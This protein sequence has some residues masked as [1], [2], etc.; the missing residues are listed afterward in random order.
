MIRWLAPSRWRRRQMATADLLD[1][2]AA[3]IERQAEEAQ[4]CER[5]LAEAR[6]EGEE[7]RDAAVS[8]AHKAETLRKVL[9]HNR[10]DLANER[11]AYQTALAQIENHWEV[12]QKYASRISA[13][14]EALK[15]RDPEAYVTTRG[16]IATVHEAL[17][18]LP[19][20]AQ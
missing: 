3:T 1:A 6:E 11:A 15:R 7:G 14:D 8:H 20:P 19:K 2:M 17:P 16:T 4:Q 12:R 18:G 13:L 10:R 9:A 5:L